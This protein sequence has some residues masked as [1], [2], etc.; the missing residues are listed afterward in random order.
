MDGLGETPVRKCPVVVIGRGVGFARGIGAFDGG[1][2][3]SF[4]V[5]V[6]LD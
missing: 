2:G 1:V 4:F 3:T 5:F 6:V